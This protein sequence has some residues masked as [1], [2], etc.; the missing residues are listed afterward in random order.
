MYPLKFKPFLVPKVWGGEALRDIFHRETVPGTLIGESW[1]ISALDEHISVVVNGENAGRTLTSLIKKDPAAILGDEI[2]A[3]YGGRFPLLFKMLDIVEPLSVQV[4]PSDASAGA[5][6]EIWY[7]YRAGAESRIW[8]GLKE[9]I[10]SRDVLALKGRSLVPALKEFTPVQGDFF[11]IPAGT[12]HSAQGCVVFEIQQSSDV[13]LRAYDWDRV[14]CRGL[15][16]M[17]KVFQAM[18]PF[19]VV[20]PLNPAVSAAAPHFMEEVVVSSS[21]FYMKK[22]SLRGLYFANT[23]RKRFHVLCGV[24]G[25]CF[26]GRGR[27]MARICPG[28]FALVPAAFGGYSVVAQDRA[29]LLVVYPC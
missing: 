18:R 3:Q 4:H 25:K 12:L 7:I 10:E 9:G 8:C 19:S 22:L 23:Y 20:N 29:E 11:Y 1:E 26:A 17:N 16:S 27:E 5:K 21:A 15:A 13:T 28:D 6:S 2:N 24:S 14:P